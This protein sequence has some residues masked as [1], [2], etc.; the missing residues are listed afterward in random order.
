ME[1]DVKMVLGL[2]SDQIVFSNEIIGLKT[3]IVWLKLAIAFGLHRRDEHKKPY[4][5]EGALKKHLR[6]RQDRLSNLQGLFRENEG[7]IQDLLK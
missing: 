1:S 5:A 7:K 3:E 2:L 6:E 4:A